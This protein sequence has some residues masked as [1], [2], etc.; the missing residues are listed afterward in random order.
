MYLYIYDTFLNNKKYLNLL[1]GIEN[2][3]ADL[4]I[5]GK[6]C[7]LN[8]L[9]NMKEVIE[10]GIKK[11]TQTIVAVGDD[12]TFSKIVN[13][14]ADLDVTL[15]IIPIN[16]K[17][18]V[19][20]ILGIPEGEKACDILAQRLVKKLDLGK[21]NHQYFIDSATID[22]PNVVLDFDKFQISPTF[23]DSSVNLC[24]LGF[25][26]NDQSIY[27]QKISVPTDGFLEAVITPNK[28]SF[29]N[30][31]DKKQSIFPFKKIMIGSKAEPVTVTIDQQAVF[32]T[33]VEVS[34]EPKKLKVIVGSKRL[35]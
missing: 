23:K 2:R 26:T 10:E 21:I 22:D 14:I 34:I 25:L 4:E 17:S 1:N 9:K 31:K 6:I 16:N 35:F 18:K 24:N 19:A 12:L 20:E 8:I 28:K 33:P 32:K 15:G 30:N 11:G 13:I 27:K 7:R 5:K 29:F 3:L